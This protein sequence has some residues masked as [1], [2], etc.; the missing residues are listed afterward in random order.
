MTLVVTDQGEF[1]THSGM[2]LGAYQ[3]LGQRVPG[4]AGVLTSRIGGQ[5]VS[6]TATGWLGSSGTAVTV[7]LQARSPHGTQQLVLT[8]TQPDRLVG[9]GESDFPWGPRGDVDLSRRP[10]T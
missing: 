4:V 3:V 8:R 5:P 10:A 9:K 6:S 1:G 2:Y 7:V